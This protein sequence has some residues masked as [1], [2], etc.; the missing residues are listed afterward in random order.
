MKIK[1]DVKIVLSLQVG[2]SRGGLTGE[3]GYT[4]DLG[5]FID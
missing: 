2:Y 5:S 3:G 1:T 4:C